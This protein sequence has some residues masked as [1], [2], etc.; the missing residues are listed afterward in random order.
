MMSSLGSAAGQTCITSMK[1]GDQTDQTLAHPALSMACPETCRMQKWG[2]KSLDPY[3]SLE[4][5]ITSN[6]GI[7]PSSQGHGAGVLPA[8]LMQL[9][10]S[11]RLSRRLSTERCSRDSEIFSSETVSLFSPQAMRL[12]WFQRGGLVSGMGAPR[13]D[14]CGTFAG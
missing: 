11:K 5:R 4:H 13:V 10:L 9:E 1:K 3:G 12:T 2:G 8:S 14:S 6:H 7:I